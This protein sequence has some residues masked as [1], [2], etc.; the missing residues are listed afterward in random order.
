MS[1]ATRVFALLE[2]GEPRAAADLLP[3]VYEELRKLAAA[4]MAGERSDHTLQATALVHEAWIRLT[5]ADGDRIEWNGRRHFFGAAAEAMRRILIDHARRRGADR[6][7]GDWLRVTLEDHGAP[8]GA[9]PSELID[10][11]AALR[12]LEADDPDEAELAKLRLFGGLGVE[13]AAAALGVSNA[14][15]KRRWSYIKARLTRELRD[16]GAGGD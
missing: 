15:V 4:K 10:L 9:D 13:E 1:D 12:R 16:G 8:V 2:A 14:T 3:L 6:R 7:G 5:G 11:D